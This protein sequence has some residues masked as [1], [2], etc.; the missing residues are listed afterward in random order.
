MGCHDG[1]AAMT[2][3]K[4]NTDDPTPFDPWS[5][6]ESEACKTCH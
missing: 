4:L 1:D 2:H 6:D 3:M 5:G